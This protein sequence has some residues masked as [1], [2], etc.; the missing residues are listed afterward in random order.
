M[1]GTDGR[2]STRLLL[3]SIFVGASDE[4]HMDNRRDGPSGCRAFSMSLFGGLGSLCAEHVL[5]QFIELRVEAFWR[6]GATQ[7]HFFDC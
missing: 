3:I 5:N 6:S 1:I 4:S 7:P 2:Y